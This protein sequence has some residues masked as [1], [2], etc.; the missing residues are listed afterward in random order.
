[1]SYIQ[2]SMDH[3][4]KKKG[5]ALVEFALMLPIILFLLLG[6]VDLGRILYAANTI[7]MASQEAV[8]YSGLGYSDDEVKQFAKDKCALSDK[9]DIKVNIDPET[10]DTET[11]RKSG[12]YVTVKIT[13]TVNYLFP[14]TN[15]ILG[16]SYDISSQSTIRVE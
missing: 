15:V 12:T 11:K 5:Q 6:I 7:N 2:G 4:K 14:L 16:P 8:R 13:Y 1:M 9:D 3:M 10:D